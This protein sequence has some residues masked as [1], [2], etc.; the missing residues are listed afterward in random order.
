[1]KLNLTQE[2]DHV[3]EIRSEITEKHLKSKIKSTKAQTLDLQ[4]ELKGSENALID[5]VRVLRW[6]AA[7]LTEL[8]LR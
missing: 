5:V 6:N 2:I 3:E 4:K 8:D 7:T 1:M